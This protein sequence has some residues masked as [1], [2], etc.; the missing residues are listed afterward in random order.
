VLLQ[1]AL[2]SASARQV[3]AWSAPDGHETLPQVRQ[4]NERVDGLLSTS[5]LWFLFLPRGCYAARSI[6]KTGSG[7][8]L[9]KQD[10]LLFLC[11]R[12]QVFTTRGCVCKLPFR[13]TEDPTVPN[14]DGGRTPAN[15]SYLL[16]GIYILEMAET[17]AIRVS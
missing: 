4:T 2:L 16:R 15:V 6:A 7:Q 10:L 11:A 8:T 1:V 12:G 13:T 5:L 9:G 14:A 17:S 3:M